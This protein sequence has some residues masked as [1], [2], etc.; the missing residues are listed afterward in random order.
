[1]HFDTVFP[2]RWLDAF[3][4]EIIGN[5]NDVTD[6]QPTLLV[7]VRELTDAGLAP[8]RVSLSVLTK[9]PSL[10]GLGYVWTS[11]S[12]GVASFERPTP[13]LETPEHLSSPIYYVMKK[14][15][16]LFL[17]WPAITE[18]MRFGILRKF[19][20]D[21]ATSYLA[22]PIPVSTDSVHVLAFTTHRKGGWS[23]A[24]IKGISGV[25]PSIGLMI[26]LTESR[27]LLGA[28][29]IAHEIA[30]RALAEEALRN[31][32]DRE[33]LVV[34]QAA[35]LALSAKIAQAANRAKGEFLAN[36]SHEI[37][38]PMN[39]I[40][41][42]SAL[43]LET[44]L[45]PKQ[46]S[47]VSGVSQSARSLLLIINDIL[48]FS[49]IDASK[50]E[51]EQA[52]FELKSSLDQI[53]GITGYMAREKG[54]RF[55][56]N[57]ASGL[58]QF[59]LGDSLR[60][61]QVLLN[62]TG[63]A[64]KFTERG[65]VGLEV[66][67]H[68]PGEQS[69]QEPMQHLVAPADEL[70]PENTVVL[71]FRVRDS[72]I[73]MNEM[74]IKALFQPFSQADTSSARKYGGTGLGLAISKGL[75]ELMGGRIWVQSEPG[76]GSCFY[77]TARFGRGEADQML[78]EAAGGT[79][80]GE[81]AAARARLAGVR[82]L[83]AEDNDFNQQVI[84]ELLERC[85]AV[86]TLCGNGQ[87]ALE[88]LDKNRFDLVLMDVQMPVM[89]GFEATRHIRARPEL[90]GQI[91]IAMTA[92]A[93][94]EDRERCLEA[95]MDDFETKPVDAERLYLLLAKWLPAAA[96]VDG[97]AASALE[98][99]TAEAASIDLTVLGKLFANDAAKVARF[100]RNFVRRARATV[101]EMEA[102]HAR[103][104][105]AA[106]GGLGHKQKSAA[107]SAGALSFATL[108]QDIEG[109]S[110]VGDWAGTQELLAQLQPLLERIEAK[111]AR[112]T[113]PDP[114]V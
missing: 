84:E 112:E 8:H 104:D 108:C 80:A 96:I 114:S 111:V 19:V 91:V 83:V 103:R 32:L 50:L 76:L 47:Y 36:M 105:L 65:R 43:C 110:K 30:Q 35:E 100:A 9:H 27:R 94:T 82:I 20:T 51:L 67:L 73:G 24:D 66:V 97:T 60:L 93:M 2:A 14:R 44:G 40:I 61:G 38:T 17:S 5:A 42:L 21:G 92:N 68:E 7:L 46:R 52:S 26:N 102:A 1:V 101:T 75:V 109:A 11:G 34:Q 81:V 33:K 13:F 37:R 22:L 79:G 39:A 23:E 113:E 88:Q 54:L 69:A 4:T 57:I 63:N 3:H 86:V 64:V 18:D 28:I 106:L 107:W 74:Q 87:E 71:E 99:A 77:F 72:G 78:S 29:G 48:D 49:K 98:A 89:D 53:D 70:P 95:G 15:L 45:N 85:G 10:S 31:A 58:P 25:V 12:D 6:M 55:E 41:G 62:L 16:R 59:V 90:A 56:S